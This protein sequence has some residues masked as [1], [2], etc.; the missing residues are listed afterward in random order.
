LFLQLRE[1]EQGPKESLA[2]ALGSCP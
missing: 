2:E 1:I